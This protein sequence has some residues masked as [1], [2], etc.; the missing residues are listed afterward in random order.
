MVSL[1]TGWIHASLFSLK[2]KVQQYPQN[3]LHVLTLFQRR[4]PKPISQCAP[5]LSAGE[6]EFEPPTNFS[7]RRGSIFRG[8]DFSGGCSFYIKNKQKSQIFIDKKS[9]SAKCF[10]VRNKN[11]NWEILTK[12]LVTFKKQDEIKDKKF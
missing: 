10:S 12:K 4:K 11:L 8:G 3:D 2:I 1:E 6:I 5:P 9:L 7:K